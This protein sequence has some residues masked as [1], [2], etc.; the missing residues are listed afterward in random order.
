MPMGED[1]A[2]K[3]VWDEVLGCERRICERVGVV[4]A[5]PAGELGA[6]VGMATGD[7]Q[8]RIAEHVTRDW[9]QQ[10]RLTFAHSLVQ[11]QCKLIPLLSEHHQLSVQ[12]LFQDL[13]F[14]DFSLMLL[15]RIH[16]SEQCGLRVTYF[17]NKCR[18]FP[19]QRCDLVQTIFYLFKMIVFFR[20][21]RAPGGC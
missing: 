11:L 18:I 2:G 14:L 8:H 19:S 9:T 15:P 10:R 17:F 4:G 20:L 5:E 16:C 12:L 1:G 3:V 21:P 13:E 7:Q 6:L